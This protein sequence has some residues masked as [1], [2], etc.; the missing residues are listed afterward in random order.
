MLS[1][2]FLDIVLVNLCQ[3]T[4]LQGVTMGYKVWRIN[5]LEYELIPL[6][7]RGPTSV[8]V[9]VKLTDK[10]DDHPEKMPARYHQSYTIL[11]AQHVPR[12]LSQFVM[13]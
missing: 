4:G 9:L 5:A 8:L 10:H 6:Y 12:W 7:E 3:L 11:L 1:L 2:I 13:S